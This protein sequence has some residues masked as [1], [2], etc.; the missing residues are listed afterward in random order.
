MRRLALVLATCAFA[1]VVPAQAAVHWSDIGWTSVGSIGQFRRTHGQSPRVPRKA[2]QAVPLARVQV[3][4]VDFQYRLSRA[5][6]AAGPVRIELVNVGEDEHD[7]KLQRVGGS[8]IYQLPG[9]LPGQRRA[10]T[11]WLKPGIYRLWCAMADH[12]MRGMRATL[13]VVPRRR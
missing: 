3:V 10:L 6:I 13:R 1:G 2:P 11:L 4:A 5:R 7:L 8:K 12:A 9:T